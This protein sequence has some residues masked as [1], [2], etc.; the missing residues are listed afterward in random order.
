MA[1]RRPFEGA[2]AAPHL[3]GA[4]FGG[5]GACDKSPTFIVLPYYVRLEASSNPVGEQEE[6]QLAANPG[7]RGPRAAWAEDERR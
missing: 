2:N 3:S 6:T 5:L 1:P 4:H 7:A